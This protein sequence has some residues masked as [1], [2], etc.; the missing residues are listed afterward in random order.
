MSRVNPIENEGGRG[1]GGIAEVSWVS[2]NLGVVGG[3]PEIDAAN[4]VLWSSDWNPVAV[5]IV[6]SR[7]EV[8]SK[9]KAKKREEHKKDLHDSVERKGRMRRRMRRVKRCFHHFLRC[10]VV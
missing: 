2:V 3:R 4:D 9:A 8:L 5:D 7:L 1:L 6:T 10:W